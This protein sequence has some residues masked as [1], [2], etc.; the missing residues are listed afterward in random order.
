MATLNPDF[1]LLSR[2]NSDANIDYIR[3]AA[4][5]AILES[6]LNES[7]QIVNFKLKQL[8]SF[9]YNDGL[10]TLANM[11]YANGIFTLSN[12]YAL[13]DGN[14]I[15]ISSVQISANSGSDIYLDT[16][17]STATYQST[18]KKYGNTQEV[19]ISNYLRDPAI[20]EETSRREIRQYAL[21]LVTGQANH[22]YLYVGRIVTGALV[23]KA[24]LITLKQPSFQTKKEDVFTATAGQT[25]FTLT[26]GTYATGNGQLE[27][28]LN[29]VRLQR[30]AFTETSSTSFTL[31]ANNLPAGVEVAAVYG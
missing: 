15:Y 29:G 3:Y 10:S 7:Q 1:T 20:G 2:Y 26:S 13:V 27:V 18:L 24:N 5:S 16:W 30:S 21:S 9:A 17:T 12:C 8:I 6:E 14:L 28:Y 4:N 31:K 22:T 23:K 25:L 19:S 11:T